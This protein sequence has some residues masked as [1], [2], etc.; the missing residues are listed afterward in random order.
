MTN[1]DLHARLDDL[2]GIGED[3]RTHSGEPTGC[4]LPRS[5]RTWH[6]MVRLCARVKRWGIGW[7]DYDGKTYRY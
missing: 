1:L 7:H 3:A 2:D 6:G 4:V 5:R